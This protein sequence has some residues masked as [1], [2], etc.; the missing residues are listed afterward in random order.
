MLVSR[1]QPHLNGFQQTLSE[2]LTL[3][4][5]TPI[6]ETVF[7]QNIISVRPTVQVNIAVHDLDRARILEYF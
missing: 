6:S 7:A 5:S 3:E 1:P 4:W 2:T